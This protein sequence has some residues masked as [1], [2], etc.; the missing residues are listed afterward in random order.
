MNSIAGGCAESGSF[1]AGAELC[2]EQGAEAVLLAGT[3]LF[4]AFSGAT[5]GFEVIDSAEVHIQALSILAGE[6]S[7]K[8]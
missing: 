8:G 2:S 6:A 7:V 1:S 3:D 5:P 4:L